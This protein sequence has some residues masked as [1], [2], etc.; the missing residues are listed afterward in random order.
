MFSRR[1]GF[2]VEKS[3]KLLILFCL[4][5]KIDKKLY[6]VIP[7]S[8]IVVIKINFE[9]WEKN[10]KEKLETED[11]KITF[12]SCLLRNGGSDKNWSKQR[13]GMVEP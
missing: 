12:F 6:D 11:S 1:A 7:L 5:S 8:I 13:R 10:W 3:V 4:K 9:N 2:L